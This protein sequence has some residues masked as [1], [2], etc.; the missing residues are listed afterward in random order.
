MWPLCYLCCDSCRY[1][2][3]CLFI[4]A[5]AE[6]SRFLINLSF[7]FLIFSYGM[8]S[9][10]L[11]HELIVELERVFLDHCIVEVLY[12][13]WFNHITFIRAGCISLPIWK[14]RIK[15]LNYVRFVIKSCIFV[16]YQPSCRWLMWFFTFLIILLNCSIENSTFSLPMMLKFLV[17]FVKLFLNFRCLLF[18]FRIKVLWLITSNINDTLTQ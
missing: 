4:P 7:H 6:A 11:V 15:V 8:L 17:Y 1:L 9:E 16:I 2:F 5:F 18:K 3:H 12:T 13:M 14:T 10:I